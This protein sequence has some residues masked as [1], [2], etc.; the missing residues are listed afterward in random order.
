[1]QYLL[2]SRDRQEMWITFL[3]DPSFDSLRGDPRFAALVRELELPEDR[4][5]TLGQQASSN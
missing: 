2:E 5:L 3:D 4:Y 1:M